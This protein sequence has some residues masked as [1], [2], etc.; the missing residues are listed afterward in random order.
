MS[1]WES[2][3]RTDLPFLPHF[4]QLSDRVWRVMGLNPGRFTLQGTNTY[5][6]GLGPRKVLID[7]GDGHP[8]YM[9]LLIESL[10][11]I[12]KEAYI[13]DILISHCHKDHWGGLNE[14][15]SSVLNKEDTIK[16]HKFPLL[17]ENPLFKYLEPFPESVVF[18]ELQDD[19]VIRVDD[20]T[21]LVVLHTPGH[22]MDHCSFY[23]KEEHAM[24]TAD[25]I[26]GHG[27][28]AFED[29]SEYIRS[30]YRIQHYRPTRLYPGHGQ[31]V[32]NGT[33]KV[34][35]YISI[36][37]AKERQIIDLMKDG[38][39]TPIELVERMNV[40]FKNY[41]ENMMAIIVRT[42]GLHLIK[43]HRDGKAEM[44]NK[45]RFEE[46]TGLD[47]YD[48]HNVFSIVNQ[49]WQLC[50]HNNSSNSSKL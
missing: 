30:L 8:E 37:L 46:K 50:N 48:P 9:P 6:V 34:E 49:K 39:A 40:T 32:E 19:Q 13:S 35:E 3:P 31:H 15:M 27:T 12:D 21:H 42:V 29:L 11:K 41:S 14:I 17:A 25:C 2:Q 10:S 36:R 1:L 7:C 22:A 5:L 38:S 23:L 44:I 4:S 43:L 47:P 33:E 24:F 28:V 20:A 16:V 26:L 18:N 45:E